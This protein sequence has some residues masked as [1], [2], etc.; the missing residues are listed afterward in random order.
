MIHDLEQKVNQIY[1]VPSDIN[2]HI[3]VIVQLAQECDHITEMGVRTV[4][5]TWAWLGGAPKDGLISY[6]LYN[7]KYWLGEGKD[8]IKDVEDTAKSYNLKFKFIEAD[9]CGIEINETD[10]LF[11]DTWHCYDQLKEELRLHSNKARKYICFH[12]TTTYAHKSEP[13]T[14]DHRWVGNLTPGKGLWDAI[15]EFIS[16]ND[17]VWEL[18]ERF[19]NNN[20]FTIIKR[21]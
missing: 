19:E 18:V 12:D 17:K 20:G 2:Q 8:P 13:T 14:S 11:I 7:P 6:D 3:P 16:E 15:T 10:L 9:V 4:V 5:S 1:T 21:K